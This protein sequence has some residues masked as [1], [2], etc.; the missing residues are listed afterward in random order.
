MANKNIISVILS[1]RENMSGK[2]DPL[3]T[4]MNKFSARTET[5]RNA[6][7]PISAASGLFLAA[8]AK[9]AFDFSGGLKEA[10]KGLGLTNA[11]LEEFGNQAKDISRNLDFQVGSTQILSL[12]TASGKLGV[13]K[14]QLA[15][16]TENLVKFAIAND[17]LDDIDNLNENVAKINAVFRMGT[18]DL[19][20]WMGAVS[21]LAD[22]TSANAAQLTRFTQSIAGTA[23][24]SKISAKTITTYGAALINSG[25]AA[26]QASTF[27]RNFAIKLG[28]AE[29]QSKGAKAAFK[30]LG[31]TASELATAFDRDANATMLTFLERVKALKQV[32]STAATRVMASVFGAENLTAGN[33]L[34]GQL[35][36]L[37]KNLDVV[38]DKKA[39]A[40]KLADEFAVSSEGLDGALRALKNVAVELAIEVGTTFL[41][42]IVKVAQA[43]VKFIKPV[44]AFVRANPAIAKTIAVLLGITAIIAPIL[45]V[46][47]TIST[48][49]GMIAPLTTG[50]AAIAG[51]FGGGLVV[52]F[53][54]VIAKIA[55]VVGAVVGLVAAVYH[56][57][58]NWGGI[59]DFFGNLLSSIPG[60]FDMVWNRIING[61]KYV[62]NWLINNF[63]RLWNRL[64]NATLN[65]FGISYSNWTKFTNNIGLIIKRWVLMWVNIY[66]EIFNFTGV[67]VGKIANKIGQISNF[68]WEVLKEIVRVVTYEV[69]NIFSILFSW[70][71]KGHNLIINFLSSLLSPVI[72]TLGNIGSAIGNWVGNLAKKAYDWGANFIAT[73]VAG[74]RSKINDV[75]GVMGDVTGKIAD[76]LPHSPAKRGGLSMLDENGRRFVE[77]FMKGVQD[78]GLSN[79]LKGAFVSPGI[80]ASGLIPQRASANNQTSPVNITYNI[81]AR[82]TEE[83]IKKLRERDRELL[84]LITQGGD[85]INR[86]AY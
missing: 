1:F 65:F 39:N 22:T 37:K 59:K 80:N 44:M 52:A 79:F 62:I 19:A 14:D 26:G 35:D 58:K 18:Q 60:L 27:M 21:V 64:G 63:T 12:A 29:N 45:G 57:Y 41:P 69:T 46:V 82:D 56:I 36:Q 53:G 78:A 3:I 85:R 11:E 68:V 73:F 25:Q 34:L 7:T 5:L 74:I 55:L 72:S 71:K 31:W 67:W 13:A 20:D 28:A 83:I 16:Y 49:I 30:T 84:K 81:S 48:L 32:D 61:N 50:F 43:M 8:S 86:N 33:L 17:K 38:G 15:A 70:I 10:R 77:T 54:V 4:K 66:K 75:V 40:K 24:A 2:I 23:S 9:A 47:G 76:F 42:A 6:M 51:L